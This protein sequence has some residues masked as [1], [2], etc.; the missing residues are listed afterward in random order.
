MKVLYVKNSSERSAEFQLKTIIYEENGQKFVKKQ[1]LCSKAV[2]HLKKMK[3]SY[4]DL[5]ACIVSPNIKLAKI[6]GESENSLTFEFIE[7]TSLEKRFNNAAKLGGGELDKIIAEYKELLETGFKSTLFNSS[8]MITNEFIKTFG[9]H[10]YSLLDGELCFDSVSN[11]D[12]IFSNIICNGGKIYLIDYEWC[13]NLSVPIDYV[14]F[15]QLHQGSELYAEMEQHFIN[16]NVADQTSFHQVHH[17]YLNK[18]LDIATHIHNQE[19]HIQSQEQYISNLIADIQ[20]MSLRNRLKRLLPA[21]VKNILKKFFFK[22]K[23]GGVIRRRLFQYV[24]MNGVLFSLKQLYFSSLYKGGG[25][26]FKSIITESDNVDIKHEGISIII[27]TYNGLHDLSKLIPQL[28]QQKGFTSIEIIIIDSSSNDG[29]KDFFDNFK[30][31]KFIS[32]K[33]KDFTHSYARNLGFTHATSEIALFMVQDAMP[34]SATWLYN[35]VDIF[36]KS[37]VAALSCSQMPNAEADLYACYGLEQ[38]SKFLH[39]SKPVTKISKK[40]IP[41][42]EISRQAAQLDNVSCLVK[43]EVFEKYLFRGKYAED[44]DLGFRLIGDKYQ[45]GMTSEVSVIHSHLRTPYY[46]MKRAMVEAE[47]L[48]EMFHQSRQQVNIDEQLAD[49]LTTSF[50]TAFFF[51][52]IKKIKLPIDFKSMR[53][54]IS[55]RLGHLLTREYLKEDYSLVYEELCKYDKDLMNTIDVLFRH[56]IEFKKGDL[57]NSI[58]HTSNEVMNFIETRYINIDEKIFSEYLMFILNAYAVGVGARFGGS[59]CNY[60]DKF[61]YLNGLFNKLQKG[62]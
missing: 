53:D 5:T 6:I 45:I 24:R 9:N 36:H 46:H 23:R 42:Q 47:V 49:I 33:Q 51:I 17:Y 56:D 26:E 18:R 62:V 60:L 20:S 52:E 54:A 19:Q 8:T 2:P 39:I 15:R 50:V 14:I 27:P 28:I 31:I 11:L 7:G 30:Q 61:Y 29:T 13:S 40:Y 55:N 10:D 58:Y 44:L 12:L 57:F 3:E 1:A 22:I 48:S 41:G 32:I 4:K 21:V 35:F 59:K 37:N 16:K 43:S 25:V 34:T 38:F